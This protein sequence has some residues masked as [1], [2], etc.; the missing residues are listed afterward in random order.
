VLAHEVSEPFPQAPRLIRDPVE[1]AGQGARSTHV[2]E[3]A[4]AIRDFLSR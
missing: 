4:A 2:A 1:L 3:I